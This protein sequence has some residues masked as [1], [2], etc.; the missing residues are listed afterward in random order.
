[1]QL[2]TTIND[3]NKDRSTDFCVFLFTFAPLYVNVRSLQIR[4]KWHKNLGWF[5]SRSGNPC[6]NFFTVFSRK[7]TFTLSRAVHKNNRTTHYTYQVKS[8]IP[9]CYKNASCSTICFKRNEFLRFFSPLSDNGIRK[10]FT[11]YDVPLKRY[12]I[13]FIQFLLTWI[14]INGTIIW[15]VCRSLPVK[16]YSNISHHFVVQIFASF[17]TRFPRKRRTKMACNDRKK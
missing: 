6:T 10:I 16:F 2:L 17:Q 5:L 13:L 8:R 4:T 9:R 11:Y 7:V 15:K 3:G 1:M 14:A 12:N